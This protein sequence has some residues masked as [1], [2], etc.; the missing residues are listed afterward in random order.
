MAAIHDATSSPQNDRRVADILDLGDAVAALGLPPYE[1][2]HEVRP[3]LNR[4]PRGRYRH[5]AEV[6]ALLAPYVDDAVAGVPDRLIARRVGLST[7][8]VKL[9]RSRRRIPGRR[10]R[11][12]AELGTRFMIAGLLGEKTEPVSH[13]FSPV[14]GA[15]RPPVYAL[16]RPLSYVL[17]T[18]M[19]SRL[20]DEFTIGQIAEGI[21]IEERDVALVLD[22]ARGGT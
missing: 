9:W 13:E 2:R 19:V 21:G 11:A 4:G 5:T 10:G 3:T 17:F 16:R 1:P 12:A 14:E 6:D 15:W 22:A 7:Q 20:A 18:R 8:Q